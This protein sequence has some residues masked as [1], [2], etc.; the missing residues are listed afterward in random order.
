MLF[1]FAYGSNMSASQMADRCPGAR[2]LGAAWLP[3]FALAFTRYSPR[4]EGGV[5][6][7]RPHRRKAAHGVLWEV[8][9]DH[10][11][12][13]DRYEGVASG[14]YRRIE[15]AVAQ[16]TGPP[17]APALTYQVVEPR[18]DHVPPAAEYMAT[19]IE[20]ACEHGLPDSYVARLRKLAPAT[21]GH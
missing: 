16:G 2:A 18:P 10:L 19:L 3:D 14:A 17:E 9:E 20:G 8:T 12:S 15:V 6:D 4:R 5:A 7:I 11:A 13:L 1:Y 21:S